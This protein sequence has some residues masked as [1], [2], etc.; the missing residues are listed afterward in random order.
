MRPSLRGGLALSFTTVVICLLL[1]EIA[2]RL[3]DPDASLWRYPNYIETW[4]AA[5]HDPEERHTI[6]YD[7]E[8]GFEPIPDSLGKAGGPPMSYSA[9]GFRNQNVGAPP[10]TGPLI[11]VLGDSYTE[12]WMVRDDESW[13]AHLERDTGRRVLNAAVSGYGLDQIVLRA[14]RLV[15]RLKPPTIVL[16]FIGSDIERTTLSFREFKHKPYFVPAGEGLELRNAPVPTTPIEGPLVV[17]RRILGYSH[18]LGSIMRRLG[19]YDLWYGLSISVGGDGV[20]ISC[21]LMERFA[22]LV[23]KQDTKA[24]VVAFQQHDGF[25]EGLT[26]AEAQ[27]RVSAVLACAG[28]A[29]LATLDTS[30]AFDAAGANRDPESFF[31]GWHYTDRGNALAARLVAAALKTAKN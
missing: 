27:K 22:A 16:A 31:V 18:V 11:L 17:A 13:P 30:A 24:L 7:S 1:A 19:A 12:G 26:R 5:R 3:R 28:K 23:R 4:A 6:R 8:L 20:V 10:A 9:Q 21:R 2:D 15:P 29:G 25:N 14:E